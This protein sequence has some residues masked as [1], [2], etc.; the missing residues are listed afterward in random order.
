MSESLGRSLRLSQAESLDKRSDAVRRPRVVPPHGKAAGVEHYFAT[1][2]SMIEAACSGQGFH[3]H[4]TANIETVPVSG[5]K[6]V[7]FVMSEENGL[8]PRYTGSS[9]RI[10]MLRSQVRADSA[11]ALESSIIADVVLGQRCCCL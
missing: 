4:F 9:M 11:V 1:A 5:P 10:Q 8:L 3:F 6:S 2:S 7:V